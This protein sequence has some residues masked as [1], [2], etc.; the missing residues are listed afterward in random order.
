MELKCS[1]SSHNNNAHSW[2]T[3]YI[4]ETNEM[5]TALSFC[6]DIYA[7]CLIFHTVPI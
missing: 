5:K 2:Y 3:H 1:L 6:E 7:H 4:I